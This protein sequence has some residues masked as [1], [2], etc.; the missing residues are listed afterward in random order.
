[1]TNSNIMETILI[2]DDTA[3]VIMFVKTLLE[4]CGYKTISA[5]N[6]VSGLSMARQFS[7]D[8]ILLDIMMPDVDGYTVCQQLKAD[9]TTKDIPVIFLSALSSS[10]DRIKAFKCGA[11]DFVDKPVQG[12]E[13]I[14]RVK[15]H[16][17]VC[18]LSRELQKANRDLEERIQ[19]RTRELVESNK[20]LVD[21]NQRLENT[22]TELKSAKADSRNDNKAVFLSKLSHEIL[23]DSNI[24]EGFA[25][26]IKATPDLDKH[27]EYADCIK[28]SAANLVTVINNM[29]VYNNAIS[30][31]TKVNIENV[32]VNSLL[33]SVL[34]GNRNKAARR[35]LNIIVNNEN[36]DDFAFHTDEDLLFT[37]LNKLVSNSLKFSE[38]GDVEIGASNTGDTAVFYVKDS[39]IGINPDLMERIYEPFVRGDKSFDM[40]G[41]G[42][43]LGLPIVKSYVQMLGGEIWLDS[44]PG[45]GSI[46]YISL[47]LKSQSAQE[48]DNSA[49][50]LE[51]VPV[52]V[53]E[54]EDVSFVLLNDILRSFG[55]KAIR[56][57]S[58]KELYELSRENFDIRLVISKLKL[59]M[60]SG[61]EA[62]KL[63]RKMH[64]GIATVAQISYFSAED[65]RAFADSGCDAYIERPANAQQ[66]RDVLVKYLV[67]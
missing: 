54:D 39:G 35:G 13:L 14:A 26:L 15:N 33:E 29:V 64:P 59:P 63:V 12:D 3:T 57:R 38:K 51:G 48:I 65:K 1:M 20:Q 50:G 7:P 49:L 66:V 56:A 27:A 61:A 24:I 43:G 21:L 30:G 42:L 37:I 44:S 47:P 17:T 45:V 6:G 46:F 10:F 5:D 22:I 4:D 41:K 28:D 8:L 23:N 55:I 31:N 53:G 36:P 52:L 34:Q 62:M 19:D 40:S 11:V 9:R 60:M 16:L 18:S 58:G 2:V 25:E 67:K 32:Y